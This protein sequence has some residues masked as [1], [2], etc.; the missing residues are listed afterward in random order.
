[1]KR[2]RYLEKDQAQLKSDKNEVKRKTF[3]GIDTKSGVKSV[4]NKFYFDAFFTECYLTI[5]DHYDPASLH[6]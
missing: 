6:N 4:S 1:M 5:T 2:I 3:G